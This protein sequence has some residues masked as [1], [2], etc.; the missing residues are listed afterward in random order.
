MDTTEQDLTDDEWSSCMLQEADPE[1]VGRAPKAPRKLSDLLEMAV[2]DA[3]AASKLKSYKLD[4]GKWNSRISGKCY[5]CMAGAVMARGLRTTAH[6]PFDGLGA[7]WGQALSAIN[8]LRGGSLYTSLRGTEFLKQIGLG[9]PDELEVVREIVRPI[10]HDFDDS[11]DRGRAS[12]A[13]YRRVIKALRAAG[14]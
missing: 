11:R 8:D 10:V 5:V 6:D 9:Y 4:M 3:I 1:N 12:W 2:K 13:T 7:M 14:F